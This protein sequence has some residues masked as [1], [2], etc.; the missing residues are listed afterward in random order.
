MYAH[1]RIAPY[2]VANLANTLEGRLSKVGF[3]VEVAYPALDASPPKRERVLVLADDEDQA[4]A[5]VRTA[6]RLTD[7]PL[8]VVR[9]LPEREWTG[10]GLK[11]F[12]VKHAPQKM[13]PVEEIVRLARKRGDE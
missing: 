4:H 9:V 3:E 12:Q 11:P 13:A 6:L 10:M 8:T 7:E 1:L 5:L 2:R